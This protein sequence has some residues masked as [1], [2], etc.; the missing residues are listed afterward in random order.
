[1][2]FQFQCPQGHLL[3]GEPN[4][5]GQQ[6]NCPMCGMLFIIPAPFAA[7]AAP[8]APVFSQYVPPASE[9]AF[10]PAAF[11][12]EFVPDQ[13]PAANPFA[14]FQAGEPSTAA[15]GVAIPDVTKPVEP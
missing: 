3:E 9:P 15:A 14:N 12:P 1:M 10:A 4:H 7:P 2:P 8:P 6:C 5:A 11:T 13:Q